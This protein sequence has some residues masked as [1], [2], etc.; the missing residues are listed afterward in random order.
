VNNTRAHHLQND[1][2]GLLKSIIDL[3]VD[4]RRVHGPSDQTLCMI[5]VDETGVSNIHKG[6]DPLTSK[7]R[8]ITFATISSF[9]SIGFPRG[10]RVCAAISSVANA[11]IQSFK[12][13]VEDYVQHSLGNTLTFCRLSSASNIGV[14]T[15]Q[16][17]HFS[18][19]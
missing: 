11:P 6:T 1:I 17:E 10:F 2:Q 7:N 18:T 15:D 3:R 9:F 5:C 4:A 8:Q 14:I 12:S 16:L 19:S 13:M